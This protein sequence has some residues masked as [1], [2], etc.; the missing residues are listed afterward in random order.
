MVVAALHTLCIPGGV[1]RAVPIPVGVLG[2]G[3]T[4]GLEE[5]AVA[6]SWCVKFGCRCL[7]LF[8]GKGGVCLLLAFLRGRGKATSGTS[9]RQR[10][11]T[12]REECPRSGG[13]ARVTL[14]WQLCPSAPVEASGSLSLTLR[15]WALQGSVGAARAG[16]FG[17]PWSGESCG[18]GGGQAVAGGTDRAV[19]C[20]SSTGSSDPY[21]IVKIDDE[22]IIR[23]V[24]L[25]PGCP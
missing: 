9:G 12:V 8:R 14:C 15:A 20:P 16:G 7:K 13:Q 24:A 4:L 21:C 5:A 10:P 22:A 3:D 23:W 1:P 18:L 17:H 25:L 6:H 2:S 19:P 11:D